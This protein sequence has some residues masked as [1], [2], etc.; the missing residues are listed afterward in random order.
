MPMAI[1]L[2]L[3]VPHDCPPPTWYATVTKRRLS[4]ETLWN[5]WEGC[6]QDTWE[7]SSR[8]VGHCPHMELGLGYAE[9]WGGAL[10][11][12][13]EDL[14][15]ILP[16]PHAFS[17]SVWGIRSMSKLLLLFTHLFVHLFVYSLTHLTSSY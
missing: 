13:S 9:A 4:W 8:V 15:L 6:R 2:C 5:A 7:E 14:E 3:W 1:D 11:F 10:D 17:Q 12:E 16:P